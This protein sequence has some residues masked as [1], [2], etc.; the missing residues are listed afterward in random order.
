MTDAQVSKLR[1]IL[2]FAAIYLIWGSTYLAIR[3]TIETIPP[4]LSAG[5]RFLLGGALLYMICYFKGNAWV[6]RKEMGGAAIVGVLMVVGGTGLVT[7]AEQFVP[8]GLAALMIAAVPFWLVLL[9]WVRPSGTRPSGLTIL[10]LVVGFSGIVILMGPME[11]GSYEGL[12]IVGSVALVFAT[13]FWAAGSI[14]SRH[15][16]LPSYKLLGVSYQM[17]AGGLVLVILSG[18]MGEWSVVNVAAF[19]LKSLLGLL[20]L[21][22]FGSLAFVCYLWLLKV[23]TPARAGTYAFVNPIVAVFLG[24]LLA[25][26]QLTTQ[27]LVAAAVIISAV[28]LITKTRQRQRPVIEPRPTGRTLEEVQSRTGD[29]SGE[30]A[31]GTE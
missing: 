6:N 16:A 26:E 24:W 28:V 7:W 13:M 25:D 1:L 22:T 10:G 19:S 3:F 9:E 21:I 4:L 11:F 18:I 23:S 5:V 15:I 29:P 17:L 30:P 12:D 8:S 2:G 27:A 31:C 20:Y 14:M